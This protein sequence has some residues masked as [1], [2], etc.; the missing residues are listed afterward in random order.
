M[1][2]TQWYT[3]TSI[4]PTHQTSSDIHKKQDQREAGFSGQ[5]HAA[6]LLN[7][8]VLRKLSISTLWYHQL[9]KSSFFLILPISL[10]DF[11]WSDLYR[12][13]SLQRL[14]LMIGSPALCIN[15]PNQLAAVK[16]RIGHAVFLH[17]L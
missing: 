4:K 12:D 2:G 9:S 17:D 16:E 1:I 14:N 11:F 15:S 8:A 13:G 7:Y 5:K 6:T 10:F 3:Y